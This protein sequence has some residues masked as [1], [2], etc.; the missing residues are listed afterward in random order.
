L[1]EFE[2]LNFATLGS[3]RDRVSAVSILSFF[4]KS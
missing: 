4:G 3:Q 2:E 1:S